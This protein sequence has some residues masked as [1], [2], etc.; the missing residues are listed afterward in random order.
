[1]GKVTRV[2][3]RDPVAAQTSVWKARL[4]RHQGAGAST[5]AGAGAVT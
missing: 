5:R 4:A 1:M 3:E 2:V